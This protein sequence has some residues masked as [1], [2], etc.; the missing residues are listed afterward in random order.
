MKRLLFV[1]PPAISATFIINLCSLFYRCGC[2]S[3]WSG[4][5]E[6]CN[7]HNPGLHHC[8]W[9]SHGQVGFGAV[10]TLVLI[11]Q[12]VLSFSP[13]RWDWRL[14]F[15]VAILVFPL[16][17]LLAALALGWTDGYWR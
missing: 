17:G 9:C 16:I 15:L 11:P 3:W 8:P 10:L 4:A 13:V 6:H 7:I 5:A 2:Q 12:L 14:R 1:V